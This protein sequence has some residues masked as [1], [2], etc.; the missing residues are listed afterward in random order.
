MAKSL[1]SK[2]VRSEKIRP[3]IIKDVTVISVTPKK[4]KMSDNRKEKIPKVKQ[5]KIKS[6]KKLLQEL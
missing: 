6:V 2:T 3:R 1:I 4:V 5:I